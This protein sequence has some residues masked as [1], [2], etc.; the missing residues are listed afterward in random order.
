MA[1][2]T[3]AFVVK[4]VDQATGVLSRIGGGVKA[5]ARAVAKA[6]EPMS[7]A[8]AQFGSSYEGLAL[9]VGGGIE[10]REVIGDEDTF[11]RLRLQYG[12]AAQAA[13]ELKAHV[14]SAARDAAAPLDQVRAA[15][16]GYGAAGGD[17]ATFTEKVELA[18]K[19]IT[20]LGGQGE[21][22]G[23]ALASLERHFKITGPDELARSLAVLYEQSIKTPGGFQEMVSGLDRTAELYA[24]LGH[25]GPEA[26]REIGAVY[27]MMAQGT[28]NAR[29]ARSE[30]QGFLTALTDPTG[31]LRRGLMSIG[32]KLSANP[33]DAYNVDKTLPVTDILKQI[34]E[35]Y[36]KDPFIVRR[37]LGPELAHDLQ[38]MFGDI[39]RTGGAKTLNDKLGVS[40]DTE[41]FLK[42][43]EEASKSLSA[44]LKKLHD[45]FDI[46]AEDHFSGAIKGLTYLFREW[47]GA[48][49]ATVNILGTLFVASKVISWIK[50]IAVFAKDVFLMVRAFTAL[51]AIAGI[52]ATIGEALAAVAAAVAAVE[53]APIIAL[54][55][56]IVGLYEAYKHWDELKATI[57]DP[58]VLNAAAGEV[59]AGG[60]YD[61]GF[62][63]PPPAAKDTP[64]ASVTVRFENAPPGTRTK[65]A[66]GDGV[67]LNLQMGYA[68]PVPGL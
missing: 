40:G 10:L 5:N 42:D 31:D 51:P 45:Q 18:A 28:G 36:Q 29:Q 59:G 21:E 11:N 37:V 55:A 35:V 57:T 34:G 63:L 23:Q 43:A 3:L 52:A 30:L 44:Q 56:A 32:V 22:V 41:K 17:V 1:D 14:L 13:D 25:L 16:S 2:L 4:A 49:A 26:V 47:G 8:M 50:T 62:T 58:A 68:L 61:T 19:T 12:M 66:K 6:F 53:L 20:L 7:K 38:T 9:A 33:L 54:T 39:A 46:F 15:L 67:D 60:P 65:D 48:V 27:A 64:S 24:T